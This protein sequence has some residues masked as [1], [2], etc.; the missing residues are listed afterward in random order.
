MNNFLL[1]SYYLFYYYGN[2]VTIYLT[3]QPVNIWTFKAVS[4]KV[5]YPNCNH[6]FI[7]AMK[8]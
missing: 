7:T 1:A 8:L 5:K 4:S 3:V 6:K 2:M